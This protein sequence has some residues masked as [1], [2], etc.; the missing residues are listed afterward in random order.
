MRWLKLT[1]TYDGGRYAGWQ[2]QPQESTVQGVL[3]TVWQSITQETV[4]VTVAG[5]TDAGVHAIG[6]VVAVGTTSL[7]SNHDLRRALNAKLP[8][9]IAVIAIDDAPP[10]FHATHD[11]ISKLYRYQIHNSRIPTV[12]DRQFTWHVPRPLDAEAMHRA[13]QALVGRHDFSSFE[14]SG[15]PRPDPVRTL[16]RLDVTR[17]SA[18]LCD[19]ITIEVEGDGFLYN[20]VRSI[21]G[22]LVPIGLGNRPSEWA[23]EVLAVR[24]RR[25]AGQT[26][27]PH[28]LFLVRV[29]Y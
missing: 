14:S 29:Q 8:D 7:L 16:F 13:G 6:Q 10:Q 18:P 24:D 17:E 1:V 4:R 9:D 5:R 25:R 11:A 20:M 28:G 2:V 23:A 12:F 19:Q 15:S 21:V 22:T 27:P 26:A 3:E